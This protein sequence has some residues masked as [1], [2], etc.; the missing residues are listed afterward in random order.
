MERGSK[1]LLADQPP[2]IHLSGLEFRL[3]FKKKKK[4]EP[5]MC[6][7]EQSRPKYEP[8]Q[9]LLAHWCCEDV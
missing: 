4:K 1:R 7:S 6:T 2:Q 9:P 3:K 5:G 8:I